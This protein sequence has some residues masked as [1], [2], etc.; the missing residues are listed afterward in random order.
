MSM[1][2]SSIFNKNRQDLIARTLLILLMP[3]SATMGF[4]SDAKS[5]DAQ[6]LRS[7]RLDAK[8]I[9]AKSRVIDNNLIESTFTA[10]LRAYG[11]DIYLP[12][13]TED[14]VYRPAFTS[15][16]EQSNAIIPGSAIVR[17]E[18]ELP[19]MNG[20][21]VLKEYEEA[22]ITIIATSRVIPS[23]MTS[24]RL[25]FKTELTSLIWKPVIQQYNED[26]VGN[27]LLDISSLK[28]ETNPVIVWKKMPT[29]ALGSFGKSS[30][31]ASAPNDVVASSQKR[32]ANLA[33]VFGIFGRLG[34][35]FK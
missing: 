17:I 20:R 19:S 23:A 16:L 12:A 9:E 25:V 13:Y 35:M 31:M 15:N 14:I 10:Q 22:N 5:V 32:S 33:S 34:E 27:P 7:T 21:Y 3:I 8:L 4:I 28:W 26:E 24:E 2:F 30:S 11:G 1:K 18:G 29:V 6:A